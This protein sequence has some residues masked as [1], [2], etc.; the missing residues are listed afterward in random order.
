[1]AN[2]EFLRF[3]TAVSTRLDGTTSGWNTQE[4]RRDGDHR[5]IQFSIAPRVG[6]GSR[7]MGGTY[8]A[9]LSR[10]IATNGYA[11]ILPGV[12][13]D[14]TQTWAAWAYPPLEAELATHFVSA[15]FGRLSALSMSTSDGGFALA[16]CSRSQYRSKP[17]L[18]GVMVLRAD[19]TVERV[20]WR[21]HTPAPDEAA[22]GQAEFPR[23]DP[24]NGLPLLLPSRGTYFR[25]QGVAFF[26][27]RQQTFP[28]WWTGPWFELPAQLVAEPETTNVKP[29]VIFKTATDSTGVH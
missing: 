1:M 25:R 4:I 14:L 6:R 18:S 19:T 2:P 17:Y 20:Y 21:F 26:Y 7:G 24:S 8:R 15:D 29:V 27:Q 12:N 3:D 16:F 13:A 11:R 28:R 23:Y 9:Q 22:G 5:L 10:E